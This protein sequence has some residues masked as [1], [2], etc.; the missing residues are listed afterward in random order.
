ME[1]WILLV[2]IVL[3]WACYGIYEIGYFCVCLT[4]W[5]KRQYSIKVTIIELQIVLLFW[6]DYLWILFPVCWVWTMSSATSSWY[7]PGFWLSHLTVCTTMT[8]VLATLIFRMHVHRKYELCLLQSQF[9]ICWKY[10]TVCIIR[11][12]IVKCAKADFSMCPCVSCWL[13][14]SSWSMRRLHR[15]GNLSLGAHELSKKPV[16]CLQSTSYLLVLFSILSHN[17]VLGIVPSWNLQNNSLMAGW[18]WLCSIMTFRKT[19]WPIVSCLDQKPAWCSAA[20]AR[21]SAI[22]DVTVVCDSWWDDF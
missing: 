12:N 11:N 18:S 5:N 9:R 13:N 19:R 7:T 22:Q 17:F 4:E 20:L 14:S 2:L 21:S 8:L 6:V 16:V 15:V 10:N 1:S 3:S